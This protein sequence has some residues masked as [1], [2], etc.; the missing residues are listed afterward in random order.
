MTFRCFINSFNDFVTPFTVLLY[1]L[2][3]CLPQRLGLAVHV[4]LAACIFA[5]R[6]GYDGVFTRITDKVVNYWSPYVFV[7]TL[8][9][10]NSTGYVN[11]SGLRGWV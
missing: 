7:T 11:P 4:L 10:A 5:C 1:F 9:V 2:D 3:R 8:W 6:L